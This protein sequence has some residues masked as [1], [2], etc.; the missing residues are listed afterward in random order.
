M[1][2]GI[3]R[4]FSDFFFEI[5][6]ENFLVDFFFRKIFELEKNI[7]LFGVEI[8]FGYSFDVKFSDLSIYDV[9]RAFGVRQR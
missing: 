2:F 3:F 6:S 9:S 4:I 7:F 1:K 5:F 8:F